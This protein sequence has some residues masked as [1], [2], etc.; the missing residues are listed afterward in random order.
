MQNEEGTSN[1][2]RSPRFTHWIALFVFSTIVLGSSVTSVSTAQIA[3]CAAIG[4]KEHNSLC[5]ARL[6]REARN[7][8]VCAGLV[9]VDWLLIVCGIRFLIFILVRLS[10]LNLTG[11]AQ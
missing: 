9:C 5:W 7:I 6:C 4:S 1:T 3:T 11:E 10:P 8:T 2:A